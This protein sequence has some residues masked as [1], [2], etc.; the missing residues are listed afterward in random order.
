MTRLICQ[1]SRRIFAGGLLTAACLVTATRAQTPAPVT[2]GAMQMTA[3]RIVAPTNPAERM[4]PRPGERLPPTA[5]AK[6]E[7]LFPIKGEDRIWCALILA[8]NEEHVHNFGPEFSPVTRKIERFFGYRNVD[9]I[10]TATKAIAGAEGGAEQW[11]VP[12]PDFWLSVRSKRE[13]NGE[14]LEDIEIFHDDHRILQTQARL[15]AE[16]PLLIRGPMHERGQLVIALQIV[17]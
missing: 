13:G 12:S 4:I 14:Y 3:Q 9:L 1:N 2:S 15:G 8:T 17:R 6:R 7:R 5:L 16:S 11:L 10:G